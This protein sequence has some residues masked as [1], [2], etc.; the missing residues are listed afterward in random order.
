MLL[1]IIKYY[2]SR[3]QAV[4]TGLQNYSISIVLTVSALCMSAAYADNADITR[5]QA[6]LIASYTH[7]QKTER[8]QH[9]T[10]LQNLRELSQCEM[11]IR[12][13]PR[14]NKKTL[15]LSA[16]MAMANASRNNVFNESYC[17]SIASI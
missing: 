16:L 10:D 9:S 13:H 3:P 14:R 8:V 7:T 15:S 2:N 4:I 17:R 1:S 5:D 11:K 12:N 6:L